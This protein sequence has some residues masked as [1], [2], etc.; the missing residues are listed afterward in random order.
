MMDI[1]SL[2]TEQSA[3]QRLMI[4]FEGTELSR[5]LKFYIDTIKVGGVILFTRNITDPEQITRLCR[6]IQ[7]YARSCGQPPLFIAIDQEGGTVARLKAPFTQFPGNPAM[8]DADDAAEFG[9]VTAAELAAIGVNMN[10]APVLDVVPDG[11]AGIMA[12]R[13]FGPDPDWV[14]ELG[15][16]VISHLQEQSIMAVAKHFPGIGR[17][18]L[19]SHLDRPSLDAGFKDMDR[20]DLVPFKNAVAGNVAG[21]MLS[22]VMYTGMDD[23]WPASL[24]VEIAKNLLRKRLG[25]KNIILTDDLDMGAI[26]KYYDIQTVM[27]QIVAA[28]IDITLICHEGPKI[29]AAYEI[30]LK[31]HAEKS[32][33][34][35]GGIEVVRRILELKRR[36]LN[37]A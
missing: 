22:H 14:S 26:V 32:A 24:S 2:S 3:G 13:A 17:T 10:M 11:F 1:T 25:F 37:L 16:A 27:E 30:L 29:E 28:D 35:Q 23:A 36:Y 20:F 12:D 6:S 4:G 9:R 33:G 19:D 34:E 31:R 21:V 15:L 5:Q 8:Q 7:D 18:T